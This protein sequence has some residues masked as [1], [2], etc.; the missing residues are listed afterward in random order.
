MALH[1]GFSTEA[2][3]PNGMNVPGVDPAIPD[4]FPPKY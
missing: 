2:A 4:F 1:L 3:G